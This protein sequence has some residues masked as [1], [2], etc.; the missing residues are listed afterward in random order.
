MHFSSSK[1]VRGIFLVCCCEL[2]A[3]F[4]VVFFLQCFD[5]LL[6]GDKMGIWLCWLGDM[7]GI[8]LYWLADMMG[9]W[10]VKPVQLSRKGSFPGRVKEE[11]RDEAG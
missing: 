8:W 9:F 4:R 2:K 6:V 11:T 10:L 7:M 1:S 5:T 3:T